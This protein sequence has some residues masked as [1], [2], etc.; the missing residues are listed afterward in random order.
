MRN[1]EDTFNSNYQKGLSSSQNP[2]RGQIVDSRG[3]KRSATQKSSYKEPMG[4][5]TYASES[6][7]PDFE[8]SSF[9]DY[10]NQSSIG[11]I[12]DPNINKSILTNDSSF[13]FNN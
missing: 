5:N 13:N 4:E 11:E 6:H 9:V 2:S 12:T 10:F 7:Q 3:S 1:T 8:N